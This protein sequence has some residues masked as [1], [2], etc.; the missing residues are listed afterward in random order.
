MSDFKAGVIEI[1]INSPYTNLMRKFSLASSDIIGFYYTSQIINPGKL[2]LIL[3][4]IYTGENPIIGS[5][6]VD[7]VINDNAAQCVSTLPLNFDE[8]FPVE[9]FRT[10]ITNLILNQM[11]TCVTNKVELIKTIISQ[12]YLDSQD[13]LQMLFGQNIIDSTLP[14]NKY[15]SPRI[16]QKISNVDERSSKIFKNYGPDLEILSSIIRDLCLSNEKFQQYLISTI[17]KN[18]QYNFQDDSQDDFQYTMIESD[19]ESTNLPSKD[20][21]SYNLSSIIPSP[22]YDLPSKDRDSSDLSST[23]PS[24]N[25]DLLKSSLSSLR[26]E[27]SQILNEMKEDRPPIIKFENLI[28]HFNS[29]L[30]TLAIEMLDASNVNHGSYG[31]L[32]KVCAEDTASD[33]E[34]LLESGNKLMLP[35]YGANISHLNDDVLKKILWYLENLSECNNQFTPLQIN[36]IRELAKRE[37]EMRV[38]LSR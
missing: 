2:S 20:R 21:D 25:Y 1:T 26:Q 29:C 28:H 23:I 30:S 13:T 31:A 12:Q 18:F 4:D 7:D 27:F 36:I 24:Q 5:P 3:Y 22:N 9:N 15:L 38:K 11:T 19:E 8:S 35:I 17:G 34:V 16:I 14:S 33:L 10:A 37:R 6:T 32:F